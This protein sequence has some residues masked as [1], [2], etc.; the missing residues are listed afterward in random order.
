MLLRIKHLKT[1][2]F[3][4]CTPAESIFKLKNKLSKLITKPAK[5]IR[6]YLLGNK[7]K[8][9]NIV[10]DNAI[11]GQLGLVSDAAESVLVV[12]MATL[13]ND[14]WELIEV[15]EFEHLNDEECFPKA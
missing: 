13:V 6:V 12:Y 5:E 1:T 8:T 7:P 4:E 11:L 14:V 9:Y 10:E 2:Y 15:P 3:V